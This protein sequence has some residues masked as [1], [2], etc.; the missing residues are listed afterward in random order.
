[1]RSTHKSTVPLV[2]G[3]IGEAVMMLISKHKD[4]STNNIVFELEH[5]ARH[6]ERPEHIKVLTDAIYWLSKSWNPYDD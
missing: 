5:T 1:M 3:V 4:V 2:T 6:E